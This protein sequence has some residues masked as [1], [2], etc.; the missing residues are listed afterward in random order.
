M[1]NLFKHIAIIFLLTISVASANSSFSG[2]RLEQAVLNYIE[3]KIESDSRIMLLSE[4]K[5][6][7]FNDNNITASI[8]HNEKL[9]GFTHIY[10]I[11]RD[12]NKIVKEVKVPVRIRV[13]DKVLTYSRNLKAGHRLSVNDLTYSSKEITDY[14]KSHLPGKEQLTGKALNKTVSSGSIVVLSDLAEDAVINKGD[15]I[16]VVVQS[17]AVQIRTLGTALNDAKTGEQVRV[18]RDGTGNMILYGR[19]SDSGMVY[20]SSNEDNTR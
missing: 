13:F 12:E 8:E 4:I 3:S 20:I 17:G 19:A 16:T 1:N 15:K 14:S 6:F 5:D 9:R 11:F 2:S 18:K 7:K 10:L